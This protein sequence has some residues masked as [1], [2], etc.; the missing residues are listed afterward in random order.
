[1]QD[2]MG[3]LAGGMIRYV[4][5]C[6]DRSLR[7]VMV[8]RLR[9]MFILLPVLIGL[10]GCNLM[11][12]PTPMPV[13]MP[14]VPYVRMAQLPGSSVDVT[15]TPAAT[16]TTAPTVAPESLATATSPPAT[17]IPSPYVCDSDS[18]D[19]LTQHVVSASLD[20]ET[21]MINLAHAVRYFNTSPDAL[22]EVVFGVEPGSI[23][24]V[25]APKSVMLADQQLTLDAV[26]NRLSVSLVE[27][28]QPGCAVDL[29][30]VY[31]IKLPKIG[32]GAYAFKGYFGYADRQINLGH[33][34]PY[35]APYIGGQWRVYDWQ[36]VGEQIV[37]DQAHWDV[38]LRVLNA[39]ALT[40]AAPGTEEVL[41]E[42][43]WR[44]VLTAARD[45]SASISPYFQ[46]LT[47]TASDGTLIEVYVFDDATRAISAGV[48]DGGGHTLAVATRSF[49]QY[50]SLF[51]PY[52]Y[53][54]L[55]VVQGDFPDGFE[56][57]GLVFV[58]TSWFYNFEG[59]VNNFLTVITIHEV[60]HQWWYA[61][62]GN[63]SA[64][65]PWLDEALATYS[66]YIY[67]EEFHPELKD[68]WWSFR[69]GWYNPQG[70]VD[71]AV[72]EF[73]D[74]RAY[75]NAIYLRGV[76]MLHNL[77]EDIGTEAFFGLLQN[78]VA[79]ADGTIA[80]PELFWSLLSPEQFAASQATRDEFFRD[81][82]MGR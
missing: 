48:M 38:T 70:D 41:G 34:L 33:W 25:F 82:A 3:K 49:E 81:P 23:E 61:R 12:D 7:R 6:L 20:Y 54:R 18:E 69:V 4:R 66:E 58:S 55:L 47:Q 36:L 16:L 1:M 2:V 74:A 73:S 39:P 9:W 40:I 28:L 24:G 44:Y 50:Q 68:W 46:I 78:Y 30:L 75:I 42:N 64:Y 67:Y 31:D 22:T 27:P 53:D 8:I 5:F 45:F 79:V 59:G 21:K 37:L 51:G 60:S 26:K 71:S 10:A 77:R 29:T 19:T 80:T 17:D 63:D 62:V 65:A 43:H 15:V 57:T 32:S 13:V 76:Q 52:P 35:V 56:F 14:T 72:Y 11:A